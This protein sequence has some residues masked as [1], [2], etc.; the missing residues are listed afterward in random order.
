[1]FRLFKKPGSNASSLNL[2]SNMLVGQRNNS[3]SNWT[4]DNESYHNVKSTVESKPLPV[5]IQISTSS[6]NMV[7]GS[8]LKTSDLFNQVCPFSVLIICLT[9]TMFDSCDSVEILRIR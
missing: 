3:T 1:M 9:L 4:P 6:D 2:N 8:N 7:A 5:H